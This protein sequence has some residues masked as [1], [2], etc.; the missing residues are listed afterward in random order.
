MFCEKPFKALQFSRI[1]VDIWMSDA[2]G[3]PVKTALFWDKSFFS[4]P[5]CNFRFFVFLRQ[6]ECY[7]LRYNYYQHLNRSKRRFPFLQFYYL[8]PKTIYHFHKKSLPCHSEQEF[9]PVRLLVK[10]FFSLSKCE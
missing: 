6:A 10:F 4:C 2:G 1:N 8:L 3:R 7:Q 5:I 9:Q